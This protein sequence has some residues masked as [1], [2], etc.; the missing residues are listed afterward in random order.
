MTPAEIKSAMTLHQIPSTRQLA[1]ETGLNYQS[2][3]MWLSGKRAVPQ[4][5]ETILRQFFEIKR[6]QKEVDDSFD[7]FTGK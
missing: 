4:Q 2:V 1:K 3:C 6:L 7:D 5:A